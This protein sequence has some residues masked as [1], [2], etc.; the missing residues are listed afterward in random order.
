VRRAR[1]QQLQTIFASESVKIVP[2][3]ET[4]L[5]L[6]GQFAGPS[7]EQTPRT[8]QPQSFRELGTEASRPRRPFSSAMSCSAAKRKISL[9]GRR[10]MRAVNA[11]QVQ[12]YQDFILDR[13]NGFPWSGH[14]LGSP[15]PDW[16]VCKVKPETQK[17]ADLRRRR[18]VYLVAGPPRFRLP[19][20]PTAMRPKPLAVALVMRASAGFIQAASLGEGRRRALSA[21]A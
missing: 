2:T 10:T 16:L 18:A 11:K 17:A 19:P 9:S 14:L 4:A 8:L 1:L 21:P 5:A 20:Q 13:R 3:K 7:L 15:I 12:P 6:R